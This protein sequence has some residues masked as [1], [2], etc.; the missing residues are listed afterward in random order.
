MIFVFALLAIVAGAVAFFVVISYAFAWYE[1]A[2]R[3]PELMEGRL[4]GSRLCLAIRLMAVES[5]C[6]LTNIALYPLGLIQLPEKRPRPGE[7]PVI[8]LHGLFHNRSCWMWTRYWLKQAGFH[9]VYAINLPPWKDVESLTERVTKKVDA[10]RHSAGIDKVHLV[11]HSMGGII[12]RNYLQIRG[13]ADRVDRL[14]MLGTPNGG[15]KL[16]ALALSPLAASL[17]PGSN[18]LQRL[19]A[20]AM[21]S[22]AKI[23]AIYSRHDNIVLPY[24]NSLLQG[25]D[26][27]ELSDI[28]HTSLLYHPK[29]FQAVVEGLREESA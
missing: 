21:P 28:G 16:A 4:T 2:N 7:T 24:D 11:G 19:D 3:N 20:A 29:A 15:S 22:D 1:Q 5:A 25:A 17:M 12:A 14:V 13:G 26:N 6:L 18:L 9:S 27:V 8:L 23:R 10:L